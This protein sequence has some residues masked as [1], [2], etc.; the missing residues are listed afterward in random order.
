MVIAGLD[1]KA[2]ENCHTPKVSCIVLV[3]EIV[4]LGVLDLCPAL[5]EGGDFTGSLN[6]DKVVDSCQ[7]QERQ[8]GT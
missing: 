8:G 5:G 6:C 3:D 4:L 7:S 1:G 2:A